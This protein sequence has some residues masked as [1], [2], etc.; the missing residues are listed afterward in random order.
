[1]AAIRVLIVDDSTVVRRLLADMIAAEPDMEVAGTAADGRI[2]LAKLEQVN[3]DLVTLD[4]EMPEM[5]GLE[6][7][8]AIRKL[9][10]KLPV[11][12]CSTLTQPAA[13]ATLD[14]LA[15]GANDYVTKPTGAGTRKE[16]VG[17]LRDDLM[18]KIRFFVR[19]TLQVPLPPVPA[20]APRP[21]TATPAPI[22]SAG[23]VGVVAIGVS[24][25]GPNALQLLLPTLGLDLPVPVLVVQHMPATFTRLLAERLCN[26]RG[27]K[28]EEASAG[29]V[30]Q[31][32]TIYIA[33]GDFH[34]TIERRDGKAV[35]NLSKEPPENSCRPAVDPLFRSVAAVY[36]NKAVAAVLTG[37]GRDGTAGCE[38]L[39][40]SGAQIL[41]QDEATSVVWGMPGLVARKGLA[42]EILPLDQLGPEIRRRVMEGRGGSARP[43][44]PVAIVQGTP[45]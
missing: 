11:I 30:A 26:V 21:K 42:D 31:P 38:H 3:P 4:V 19:G 13:A 15:L 43:T 20:P 33:P 35:L 27:G 5:N 39:R 14:A 37:M 22:G 9:R 2:A 12:M 36:G 41:V 44:R 18:G 29:T 34:M 7:L 16:A 25:G 24:T 10:P 32:G 1:V 45:K 6:T 28:V 23:R 40:E 17:Q 8:A